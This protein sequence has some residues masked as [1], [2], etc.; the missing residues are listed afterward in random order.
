MPSPNS[1][2]VAGELDAL[3]VTVTP[4]DALPAAPGAKVA[5]RVADWPG[6][7]INPAETPLSEKDPPAM[8]TFDMVTSEFPALVKVTD[9]ELVLPTVTFPKFKLGTLEVSSVVAAIAVP[10]KVTVLGVLEAL[11][12]TETSPDKAPGVLG[13]NTTSKVDCFPAGITSGSVAPETDTPAAVLPALE[14]VTL[15]AVP[16]EIVIDWETLPPT[17]TLPKLMDAG[18]TETPATVS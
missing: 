18:A 12:L 8:L 5:S 9:K 6:V 11:V 16:L 13:L 3:L 17:A 1:E 15:D 4:P 2:I 14:M 10:L 7:R